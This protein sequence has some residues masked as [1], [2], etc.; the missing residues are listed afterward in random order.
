MGTNTSKT[1]ESSSIFGESEIEDQSL[2]SW[3]EK[4]IPQND[5]ISVPKK[6]I[7]SPE[8]RLERIRSAMRDEG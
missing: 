5:I 1:D 7:E 4:L 2:S 8:M 3:K 6:S